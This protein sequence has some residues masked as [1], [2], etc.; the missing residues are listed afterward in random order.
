[1]GA[2]SINDSQSCARRIDGS[3]FSQISSSANAPRTTFTAQSPRAWSCDAEFF[4]RRIVENVRCKDVFMSQSPFTFV[5]RESFHGDQG[6]ESKTRVSSQ[7]SSC[8]ANGRRADQG[9]LNRPSSCSSLE[10]THG[11]SKPF[12]SNSSCSSV[13]QLWSGQDLFGSQSACSSVES[14]RARGRSP[15]SRPLNVHVRSSSEKPA[16]LS[17]IPLLHL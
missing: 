7:S 14:S 5:A 13:N 9:W 17:R 4:R 16:G 15:T 10:D 2:T 12:D 8:S 1:M 6:C 3:I 11:D